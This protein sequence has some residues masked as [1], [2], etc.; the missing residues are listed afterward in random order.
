VHFDFVEHKASEVQIGARSHAGQ[1]GVDVAAIVF[2]QQAV[3]FTQ[4]EVVEVSGRG[5]A[6]NAAHPAGCLQAVRRRR[7]R[8]SGVSGHT[9]LPAAVP[10]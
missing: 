3:P 8:S 5:L 9:M 4:L 2:K 1:I 6:Q 7:C 10:G